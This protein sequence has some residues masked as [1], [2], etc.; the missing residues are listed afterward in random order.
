[1][2]NKD[3]II[4]KVLVYLYD[5]LFLLFDSLKEIFFRV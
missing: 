2:L 5:I 4:L 1:M 3:I